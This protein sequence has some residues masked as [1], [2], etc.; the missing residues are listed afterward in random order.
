MCES[1]R[2]GVRRITWETLRTIVRSNI[3]KTGRSCQPRLFHAPNLHLHV[4]AIGW[5]ALFAFSGPCRVI[6]AKHV[7]E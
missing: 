4:L 7:V 2:G 5:R 3:P 1:S 6:D